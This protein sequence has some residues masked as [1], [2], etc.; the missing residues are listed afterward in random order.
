MAVE[1]VGTAITGAVGVAGMVG[2]YVGTRSQIEG[3]KDLARRVVR[4]VGDPRERFAEDGLRLLRAARFSATLGFEAV[5]FATRQ[6]FENTS[7]FRIQSI[8]SLIDENKWP[9]R[10]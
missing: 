6:S 4:A 3:Q 10:T 1:W 7:G 5:S 9:L 2:T 8:A